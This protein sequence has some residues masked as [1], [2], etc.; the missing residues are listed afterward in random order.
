MGKH[1]SVTHVVDKYKVVGSIARM[2]MRILHKNGSLKL[3]EKHSKQS[4][5]TPTVAIVEKTVTTEKE[6][7]KEKGKKKN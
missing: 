6:G 2:L 4:L 7:K 3:V 1:I 5:Y